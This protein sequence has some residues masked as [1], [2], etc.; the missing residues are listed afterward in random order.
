ML[1]AIRIESLIVAFE[2]PQSAMPTPWLLVMLLF[3]IVPCAE[4]LSIVSPPE[5]PVVRCN[6]K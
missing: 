4:P 5:I 1:S 2:A 3:L 6:I